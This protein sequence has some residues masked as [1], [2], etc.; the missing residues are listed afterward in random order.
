ML[1]DDAR[2]ALQ[3]QPACAPVVL[4]LMERME[5]RLR[6]LIAVIEAHECESISCDRDGNEHCDCLRRAT[7]QAKDIFPSQPKGGS[8]GQE[9]A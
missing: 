1:T 9:P 2:E 4:A 7:K 5:T 3:K 6:E 8:T